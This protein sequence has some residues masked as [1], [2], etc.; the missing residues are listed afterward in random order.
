MHAEGVRKLRFLQGIDLPRVLSAKTMGVTIVSTEQVYDDR[1]PSFMA[2]SEV[3]ASQRASL[4][5]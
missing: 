4:I 5:P 3:S 2:L 1:D